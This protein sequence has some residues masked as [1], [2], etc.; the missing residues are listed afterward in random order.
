MRSTPKQHFV[1]L[2]VA[3][4]LIRDGDKSCDLIIWHKCQH[5]NEATGL[6]DIYETRPDICKEFL[7]PRARGVQNQI[8]VKTDI[9]EIAAFGEEI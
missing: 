4:G 1:D 9:A 6:C 2:L 8:P 3:H 5:L 7:C